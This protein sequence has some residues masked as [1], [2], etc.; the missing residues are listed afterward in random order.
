MRSPQKRISER[1]AEVR[2]RQPLVE[3]MVARS[4]SIL[5]ECEKLSPEE[6]LIISVRLREMADMLKSPSAGERSSP[7]AG[8][9]QARK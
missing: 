9:A 4:R 5:S 8:A 1:E 2:R 6:R 3:K 7:S